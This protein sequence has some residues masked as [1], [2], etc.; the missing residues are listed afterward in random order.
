MQRSA[1]EAE[2]ANER[3][4]L[5]LTPSSRRDVELLA[6]ELAQIFKRPVSMSEA[7]RTAVSSANATLA[8]GGTLHLGISAPSYQ[9]HDPDKRDDQAA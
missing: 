2:E 5:R 7:I 1:S 8:T 6:V 3:L 9:P 4:N